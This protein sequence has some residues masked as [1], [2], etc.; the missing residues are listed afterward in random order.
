MC[1]CVCERERESSL[2]K[3][4]AIFVAV[5]SFFYIKHCDFFCDG[6]GGRFSCIR[7]IYVVKKIKGTSCNSQF[8]LRS[9]F[10]TIFY[11]YIFFCLNLVN[12][13][14]CVNCHVKINTFNL[15][16]FPSVSCRLVYRVID[17]DSIS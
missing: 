13:I 5:K 2:N 16:I 8:W 14:L 6:G 1:V 17:D 15:T 9:I 4:T 3:K 7:K 12:I 11:F 10:L